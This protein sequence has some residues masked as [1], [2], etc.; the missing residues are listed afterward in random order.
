[1][2]IKACTFV[3]TGYFTFE[4][5]IPVSRIFIMKTTFSYF[6]EIFEN[7]APA[8]YYLKKKNLK[9]YEILT[10]LY[11]KIIDDYCL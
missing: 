4:T 3:F 11:R 1:M 6:P 10:I 7:P 8:K 5:F 9:Y 2:V